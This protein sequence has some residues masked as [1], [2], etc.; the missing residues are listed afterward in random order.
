VREFFQREFDF[1]V[2]VLRHAFFLN[3]IDHVTPLSP[4]ERSMFKSVR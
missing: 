4:A 3:V 1:H 2:D